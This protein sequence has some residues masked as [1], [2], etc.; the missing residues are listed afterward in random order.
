VASF[1]PIVT[2]H[3]DSRSDVQHSRGVEQVAR[4]T[5]LYRS[6]MLR[7]LW[8]GKR[9]ATRFGMPDRTNFRAAER[10]RS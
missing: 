10:R 8:P 1:C 3:G 5:M 9:I 7:V 2:S 6:K 4:Q